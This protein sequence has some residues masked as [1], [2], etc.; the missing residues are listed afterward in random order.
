MERSRNRQHVQSPAGSVFA[1]GG[2]RQRDRIHINKSTWV[3]FRTDAVISVKNQLEF[4]I[5]SSPDFGELLEHRV[6]TGVR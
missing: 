4:R 5:K 6:V 2:H 3:P 1:S